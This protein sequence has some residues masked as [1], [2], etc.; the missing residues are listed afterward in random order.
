MNNIDNCHFYRRIVDLF[1]SLLSSHSNTTVSVS[2]AKD[3]VLSHFQAQ[4]T[5]VENNHDARQSYFYSPFVKYCFATLE[6][7][8][9]FCLNLEI[10]ASNE[11]HQGEW[12]FVWGIKGL[13]K[14]GVKMQWSTERWET[15][16]AFS[17]QEFIISRNGGLQKS[18][19]HCTSC[20]R[21]NLH[22]LVTIILIPRR[23]IIKQQI[24][25]VTGLVNQVWFKKEFCSSSEGMSLCRPGCQRLFFHRPCPLVSL[26][27][28]WLS[29][30]P[31][32]KMHT[33]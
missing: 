13:E 15:T 24:S 26:G 10:L 5:R 31:I 9:H 25:V 22:Q 30:G 33:K 8:F 32:T 28:S 1:S 3:H 12:K 29:R 17:Y 20:F 6:R 14:S 21:H 16:F 18:L 7:K 2:N 19:F 27:F 11:F 23:Q 4:R